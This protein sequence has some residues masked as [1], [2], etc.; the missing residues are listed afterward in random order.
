MI[1]V[2]RGLS[3]GKVA[4]FCG[5]TRKTILRWVQDGLMD[6]FALPSGHHRV[7][8]TALVDFLRSNDMPVPQEL[9]TR[10]KKSIMIVDDDP[11]IRRIISDLFKPHFNVSEAKNGVEACIAM[12]ANPPDMLFLDNRMPFMDGVEVCRQLRSHEKLKNMK[13]VIVSAHLNSESY[14]VLSSMA[15][16][17]IRKPFKPAE[18]VD[19]ALALAEEV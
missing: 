5:V 12:G 17:V 19:T 2:D 10:E 6:S 15:D 18:L 3:L 8:R 16:K 4:S 11:N 13:I 7:T 14:A 1:N 9:D